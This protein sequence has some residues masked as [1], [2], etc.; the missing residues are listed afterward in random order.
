M[1]IQKTELKK[2]LYVRGDYLLMVDSLQNEEINAEFQSIDLGLYGR[3]QGR[4]REE[5][6]AIS[7]AEQTENTLFNKLQETGRINL[8]VGGF[9]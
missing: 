6:Q 5:R 8:G 9:A 7:R 3:L 2:R 1:E 4:I